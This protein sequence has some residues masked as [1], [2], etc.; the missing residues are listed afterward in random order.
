MLF[1]NVNKVNFSWLKRSN[2]I[3]NFV[4]N[5]RQFNTSNMAKSRY[6]Y[7]KVRFSPEKFHKYAFTF[8][9]LGLRD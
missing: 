2:W 5:N 6:E 4:R 1:R 9:F 7:V 3:H 8:Q